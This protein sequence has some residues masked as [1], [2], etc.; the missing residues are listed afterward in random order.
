M[1]TTPI[2]NNPY[3]VIDYLS[4][5]VST[6]FAEY[7]ESHSPWVMCWRTNLQRYATGAH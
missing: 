2:P 7:L 3:A 4:P 6:V 1:T 5:E